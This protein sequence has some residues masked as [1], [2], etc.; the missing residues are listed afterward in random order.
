MLTEAAAALIAA[1]IGALTNI[2]LQTGTN[3]QNKKLQEQSWDKMSISSRVKELEANGLNKQ[4]AS[5][6][7]PNYSLQTSMKAPEVNTGKLSTLFSVLLITGA[8]K[9]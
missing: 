5:G 6:S 9:I 1:G 2:I 4:L 3:L 8:K 7:A